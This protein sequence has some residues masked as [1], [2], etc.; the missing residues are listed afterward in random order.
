MKNFSWSAK[1]ECRDWGAKRL[2]NIG[3]LCAKCDS[4]ET[5]GAGLLTGE[6]ARRGG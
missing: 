5:R 2:E 6:D 3:F 4:D 1:N